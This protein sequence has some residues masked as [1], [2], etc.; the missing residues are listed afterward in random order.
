ML[1]TSH[2]V[3]TCSRISIPLR[4][5][6]IKGVEG[7]LA[8]FL[9]YIFQGDWCARQR[10]LL[11]QHVTE[12]VSACASAVVLFWRGQAGRRMFKVI[13]REQRRVKQR[14]L[15]FKSATK[16]QAAYKGFRERQRFHQRVKR[17][18]RK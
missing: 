12:Y 16:I 1:R 6:Y 18:W 14:I 15:E 13:M 11:L 10:T 17:T 7:R 5:R 8:L 2:L 3:Y 4:H 9:G